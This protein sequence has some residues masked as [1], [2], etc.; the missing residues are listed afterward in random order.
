MK[1][2]LFT[3]SFLPKVGGMEYVIHYLA[4]ALLDAGVDVTVM[5]R[6]SSQ[7]DNFT[8]R[9]RLIR[10]GVAFRGGHRLHINHVSARWELAKLIR[11][12]GVDL[13]HIHSVS[14]PPLLCMRFLQ[15][16]HIPMVMTPHGEDVQR[17]PEIGY[18]ARLQPKWDRIVRRHLAAADAVTAISQ[19]IRQEMDFVE[20]GKIFDVPNGIHTKVFDCQP[21]AFL[22]E[23]LGLK[24]DTRIILSVG[25]NHIKKGYELGI[26]AIAELVKSNEMAGWYYV[27]VGK[28]VSTLKSVVESLG[29]SQWVSLVEVVSPDK[30]RQCYNSSHIF[31]SP[32]IVEGLSLVSIEAM[33]CGLPLVVTDVPGNEDV[34]RDNGCGVIVRSKDVQDMARGLREM[35]NNPTMREEL[36]KLAL[37]R[38]AEYDWQ[39]IA[40]K[41]IEVYKRTLRKPVIENQ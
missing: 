26:R 28:G 5:A 9:Y 1:V 3:S 33:A 8:H 41:Y 2:V 19:S 10:Y 4:E 31:F 12:Q 6:R 29:L 23:M 11:E 17:I 40:R 36:G 39:A 7:E 20:P 24:G 15:S 30:L 16:R 34:V 38:S 18:G 21:S 27:L 22:Q 35:L 32:S 13:V 25:R 14:V 37:Q